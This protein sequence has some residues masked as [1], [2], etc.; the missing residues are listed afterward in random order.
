MFKKILDCRDWI[1][2]SWKQISLP[3]SHNECPQSK[4]REIKV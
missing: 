4:G 3:M 1:R 2:G